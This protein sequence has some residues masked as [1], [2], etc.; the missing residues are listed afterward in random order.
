MRIKFKTATSDHTVAFWS[1][2]FEILN[3]REPLVDHWRDGNVTW[4]PRVGQKLLWY[5]NLPATPSNMKMAYDWLMENATRPIKH[6]TAPKYSPP[7]PH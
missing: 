2:Y 6:R 4:H 5:S 7:K 3:E 1:A